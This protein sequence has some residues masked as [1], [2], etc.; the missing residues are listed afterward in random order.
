MSNLVELLRA[1]CFDK[2]DMSNTKLEGIEFSD[3]EIEFMVEFKKVREFGISAL[4][5]FI[6][7]LNEEGYKLPEYSVMYYVDQLLNGCF[8]PQVAILAKG[9]RYFC[10]LSDS[11]FTWLS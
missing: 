1:I 5:K 7:K 9:K 3:K 8:S 2:E 10:K 11:L 6:D 4:E